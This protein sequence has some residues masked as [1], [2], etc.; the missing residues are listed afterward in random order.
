MKR[1]FNPPVQRLLWL[2]GVACLVLSGWSIFQLRLVE[3]EQGRATNVDVE[4]PDAK[5][6]QVPPVDSYR[7]LVEA[8]L[9]WEARAV[10]VA[11]PPPVAEI[12]EAIPEKPAE[13]VNPPAG[14]LVGIVDLGEKLYAVVRAETKQ[15]SLYQGDQWEGWTVDSI[16]SNRV[17]LV[18]GSQRQEVPLIAD[19]AA[20]AENQQL[21]GI[22]KQQQQQR[23]AVLQ[24][25]V[26]LANQQQEPANLQ[27]PG[28]NPG[29]EIP[30]VQPLAET[31]GAQA[32]ATPSPVMSIKDALEA[33]Q[34]LMASRWGAAG[35]GQQGVQKK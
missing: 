27:P 2:A 28:E 3:A 32:E 1:L 4:I 8:P 30:A 20:P 12:T 14:R 22:R 23:Q 33:R 26:A 16:D 24:R 34:R 35:A 25:Q 29:A 19:F 7:R 21:A 9:F 11:P 13:P 10:P 6:L 15:L 5:T 18:A 31:A 17:V